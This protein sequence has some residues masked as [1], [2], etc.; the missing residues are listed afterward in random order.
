MARHLCLPSPCCVPRVG[1]PLGMRGLTIDPYGDNI[2]SVSN[3]PGGCMTARHDLVKT[4]IS[5]LC[6]DSGLRAD[7]EVF[8]VFRDLIPE[9]ALGVEENLHRG[10][11]RQGLLPD[12]RIDLPGPGAEAGPGALGNVVSTLAEVKVIGAVETYYPRS[13]VLARRKKGVERR[14]S[15]VPGEYR[16]PL[17]ALDTRYHGTGQ[18][19]TGPLVRRLESH[20]RLLCWVMGAWQEASTDLHNL[21]DLLADQKVS[22]MG[23]ARGREASER[24]RSQILSNYRRILSTTGARASS[25]CLIGRVARVGEA[26]RA[27]AKRR[28]WVRTEGERVEEL[29]R[30]HWRAHVL[31]RG[32]LRGEFVV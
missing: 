1:E 10:R 30:V 18:G 9:D 25:G 17:A 22:S 20:G 29:R 15:R 2:L 6:L 16:R 19:E 5:S 4:T 26:H 8:G 28:E 11:G 27:A 21:L 23:L 24:E 7:C 14:G 32:V 3:I 31:G 13:G 12:F